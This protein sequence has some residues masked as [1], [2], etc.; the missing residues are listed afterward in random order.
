MLVTYCHN[1]S[2]GRDWLTEEGWT[3]LQWNGW[4]VDAYR[5]SATKEFPSIEAAKDEFASITGEDPDAQGCSCC[6]PPHN[7]Y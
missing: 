4:S 2:G 5:W 3:R 6:G 1:N 7:F